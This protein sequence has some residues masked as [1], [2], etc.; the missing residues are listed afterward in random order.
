MVWS[1]TSSAGDPD[2]LFSAG[3]SLLRLLRH[4]SSLLMHSVISSLVIPIA[5]AAL[6]YGHG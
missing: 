4:L 1:S 5:E 6:R 3:A 2:S